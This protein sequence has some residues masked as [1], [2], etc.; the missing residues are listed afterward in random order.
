M[1]SEIAKRQSVP[2]P[3]IV[4]KQLETVGSSGS[5]DSIPVKPIVLT[6]GAGFGTVHMDRVGKAAMI[7]FLEHATYRLVSFGGVSCITLVASLPPDIPSYCFTHIRPDEPDFSMPIRSLLIKVM[8]KSSHAVKQK[9]KHDRLLGG[10]EIEVQT[11]ASFLSEIHTQQDI[12]T[13]SIGLQTEDFSNVLDALCPQIIWS[14]T[15]TEEHRDH[16]YNIFCNGIA[17]KRTKKDLQLF[18][19]NP[20][21]TSIICMEYLEGYNTVDHYRKNGLQPDDL[22]EP[23]AYELMRLALC[24]YIHTDLH[25]ENMMYHPDLVNHY[26]EGRKGKMQLIDFGRVQRISEYCR[27]HKIE[28]PQE[29]TTRDYFTLVSSLKVYTI[30]MMRYPEWDQVERIILYRKTMVDVTD[31]ILS[32]GRRYETEISES[33]RN[34]RLVSAILDFI[35]TDYLDVIH[36]NSNGRLGKTHS[37]KSKSRKNKNNNQKKIVNEIIYHIKHTIKRRIHKK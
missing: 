20:Y 37:R 30:H 26:G 9:F 28:F 5:V 13:K 18:F 36:R 15:I 23:L 12:F 19:T 22:S 16:Y 33:G 8:M 25:F 29:K 24:G 2:P 4:Q 27:I 17:D 11:N 10:K 7:H 1:W 31:A 34:P 21:Q 6:H 14:A 32:Y 3:H 35:R